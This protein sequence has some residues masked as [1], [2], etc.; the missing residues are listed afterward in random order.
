MALDQNRWG[1]KKERKERKK[2]ESF[3][4]LGIFK[5][6]M[7]NLLGHFRVKKKSLLCVDIDLP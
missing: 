3:F 4:L 1:K 6:G 5:A 7:G 2:K